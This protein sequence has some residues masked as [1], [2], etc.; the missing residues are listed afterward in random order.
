MDK[1][2]MFNS[3]FG[4]ID[5]FGW[6]GLERIL[7]NAGIQFTSIEFQDECQNRGIWITLAAPDN[8]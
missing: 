1:L 7:A 3:R 5:K 4:K 2:D 8:Q 6:W